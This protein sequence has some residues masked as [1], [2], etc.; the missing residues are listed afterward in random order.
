MMTAE[1]GR[2]GTASPG[3]GAPCPG[4]PCLDRQAQPDPATPAVSRL[5]RPQPPYLDIPGRRWPPAGLRSAARP[6]APSMNLV[7]ALDDPLLFQPLFVGSTWDPWRTFLKALF[8]GPAN[9]CQVG[10]VRIS[11]GVAP[12]LAK[13]SNGVGDL[14]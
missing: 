12:G 11:T 14:D 5:A 10:G 9:G 4:S 13:G 1:P 6:G 2:A 8:G 7:A 3:H